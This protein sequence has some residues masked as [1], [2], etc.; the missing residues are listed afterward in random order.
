MHPLADAFVSK[1]F[2]ARELIPALAHVIEMPGAPIQQTISGFARYAWQGAV[3]DAIGER[4][5]EILTSKISAAQLA[6]SGR[7]READRLELGE[8]IALKEALQMLGK[9]LADKREAKQGSSEK[10]E[11]A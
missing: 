3:F 8:E 10:E 11:I 1:A 2:A 4:Q 5:A 6:I 9:L 7:L